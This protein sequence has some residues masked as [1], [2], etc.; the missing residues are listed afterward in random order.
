LELERLREAG[1]LVR[2]LAPETLVSGA[3]L[4]TIPGVQ[5]CDGFFVAMLQKAH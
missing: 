3:Y 5:L 2:T 1:E 4:R